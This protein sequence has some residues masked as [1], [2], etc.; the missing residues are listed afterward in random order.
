MPENYNNIG[1]AIGFAYTLPWFGEGKTTIRGG[2]QQTFGAAG[3]NRSAGIGGV[4]G[5][6]ANAPG[7]TTMGT[8]A[9]NINNSVYQNILATRAIGLGDIKSLVPMQPNQLTPGTP[10]QVYGRSFAP[11]VYDP[12]L[13]T[14]YT[15]NITLS[16][17]RSDQQ[18]IHRGC[19]IHRYAGQKTTGHIDINTEQRL[20]QSRAFP[21]ADGCPGRHVYGQFTGVQSAI[22]IRESVP[23][24]S[25]AILFFWINCWQG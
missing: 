7:A 18:Q 20:L 15:Q 5:I 16:V 17:T 12:K 4:E 8:L 13:Q 1:P 9:V 23:A 10:V 22:P 3:Q 25:T 11:Q 21:G 24:I 2:Y 14:P 6:I 19:A